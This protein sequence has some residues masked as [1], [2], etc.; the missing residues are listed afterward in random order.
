MI[1]LLFLL[2]FQVKW[3]IDPEKKRVFPNGDPL[4][5]WGC[6]D[7]LKIHIINHLFVCLFVLTSYESIFL[8]CSK[9]TYVCHIFDLTEL[10]LKLPSTKFLYMQNKFFFCKQE[11]CI[12][13]HFQH[14][15]YPLAL[16]CKLLEDTVCTGFL[17]GMMC[18]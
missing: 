15:Y 10:V 8:L 17:Y 12:K 7:L 16:H 1:L 9:L 4:F 18:A 13:D 3:F 11:N 14:N 2:K 5:E 6:I